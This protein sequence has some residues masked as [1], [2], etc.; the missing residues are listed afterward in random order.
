MGPELRRRIAFTVGVLLVYRLGTC[1]PLPGID[2]TIWQQL[3][4]RQPAG[5]HAMAIFALGIT[6][7][8]SAAVLLRLVTI[9]APPLQRLRGGGERGNRIICAYALYLALLFAAFQAYVL[10]RGLEEFPQL[11]T[12]PGLLFRISTVVML[13]GGT[14]LAIWLSE[15]ITM[16]GVGNGL[17]LILFTGVVIDFMR[18]LPAVFAASVDFARR[19]VFESNL[20]LAFAFFLVA[21]VAMI[22]FM[23]LA[24]RRVPVEYPARQVGHR[25]RTSSL[26][27]KLNN[28]GIIPIIVGSWLLS[29]PLVLRSFG[30]GQGSWFRAVAAEFE[31]GRPAFL[32]ATAVVI[33]L[34]ALLYTAFVLDPD[35][36]AEKLKAYGGV[37]PG[38][39]PGEATAAHLDFVVS[40]TV[41]LGA[42]YLA[43]I[44]LIPDLPIAYAPLPFYFDGMS[45][46]V[47]VCVVL[48][49]SAQVRGDGLI[50][51]RG[52]RQ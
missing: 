43:L 50:T 33:I 11:V 18:G 32:I 4:Q 7:Y 3:G 39:A 38:I 26:S 13:T 2:L 36:A 23:E 35:A 48:D 46:L 45:A 31:H 12:E 16:W 51:A 15:Q 49:V 30:G 42:A 21:F 8:M 5:V 22:V 37:V 44:V 28:A 24:R 1:I 27:L 20:M 19:G 25:G 14:F 40:R 52:I 34:L 9:V 17:A 41:V 10:S 29:L 6:P 47:V